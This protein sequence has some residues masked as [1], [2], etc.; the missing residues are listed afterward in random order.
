[1]KHNY[2]ID[3]NFFRDRLKITAD[4]FFENRKDIL[5]KRQTI[6]VFSGLA[7]NIL[8]VV[9]MGKVSN[10]GYEIDV[11]WSDNVDA[12]NY[13]IDA[14]LTYSKN[15][16]VEMDEVEPNEEYMKRTGTSVGTLFG[17]V[18]DR[19]YTKDDF[20]EDGSLKEGL[21]VP[22]A[23]VY[24]GDCKFKDMNDDGKID[25]Y[26]ETSIGY[27]TRPNYVIGLNYGVNYKGWFLTMNWSGAAERSLLLS[28]NFRKPFN[29]GSSGLMMYH[30]DNRWTEETAETATIPR[31]SS[32]SSNHNTQ[33]S[34][35]W[36]KDGSY[37]KLKT[38]QIGYTFSNRPLLKKIGISQLGI[39]CSGYNLLTFDKFKIMDPESSPNEKNTYPI[40]KIYNIGLNIVF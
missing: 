26:D 33:Q 3:V 5:I 15:K 6:P 32:N 28:D 22:G 12:F 10:K 4:I 35:L 17:L 11:K 14:N 36:V 31:F 9:N 27:S 37:M 30:A 18:F 13:W 1:M 25:V 38:V 40:N 2:G 16:R 34:S 24:P 23:K 8:P 21:A 39:T 7:S 19:F 29:G 20:N